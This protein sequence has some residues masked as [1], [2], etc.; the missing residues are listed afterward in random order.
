MKKI[1]EIVIIIIISSGITSWIVSKQKTKNITIEK[2]K[3][4]DNSNIIQKVAYLPNQNINFQK[5][6][7]QAVDQ[8]VHV[9]SSGSETYIS[10]SPFDF[11][12]GGIQQEVPT[13]S[14]GSGV[15]ISKS[16]YIIT[17]NHVIK[18]ADKIEVILNNK[19]TYEASIVGKDADT[20]LALLKI[21]AKEDLPYMPYGNS[22]D[23]HIGEWVLAIGNPFNL[24]TTVTA[25]IISAK[26][27]SLGISSKTSLESFIQTDA[28][29]NPGNSGGALVNTKGEL[30]GINTAIASRT[31]SYVGYAFAIPVNIVKKVV[32][33]LLEYGEVQRAV[34]GFSIAN[35]D[36]ELASQLHL[37]TKKG[38][39]IHHITKGGAAYDA[40][41]Q[42][43]DILTKIDDDKIYSS[44]ELYEKIGV[45]RPGDKISITVLREQK[46]LTFLLTLKNRDNQT[47][48]KKTENIELLGG[49]FKVLSGQKLKKIGLSNGI[50]ITSLNPGKLKRQGVAEGFI[51]T[52]V[53]QQKVYSIA[54]L[55][56]IINQSHRGILIEGIYPNG[57][58]AYYA[59]GLDN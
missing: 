5:A 10:N 58:R 30:I 25:G 41:I 51:I 8:V 54:D 50:Q 29:V 1:V 35:I 3:P 52:Y 43:G 49:R 15:I 13:L 45:R 16:G 23:I 31:G 27:R 2:S 4:I 20:D 33:D 57:I 46:E 17:N 18:N 42:E 28:A 21:N 11:I 32:A 59:I 34:L 12:F 37:K 22:D 55:K 48:M 44:S 19:E 26:A 6:A 7:E 40:G 56:K 47:V 9:M 39:Y 36:A 14:S 38:L 24:N 53:N